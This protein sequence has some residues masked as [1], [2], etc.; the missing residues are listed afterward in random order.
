MAP[1]PAAVATLATRLAGTVVDEF[2]GVTITVA[3]ERWVEAATTA[4]D[5]EALACSY[6]DMLCGVDEGDA[7]F[8]VVA[9][10]WSPA[11]HHRLLLRTVCPRDEPIVPSLTGVFRGANWHEREAAEMYGI[12]FAGHPNL[13]PLLLPDGFGAHPM[14][15]EFLLAARA[16]KAWPGAKE[17][18]EESTRR[19]AT[20]PGQPPTDSGWPA[21]LH[22]ETIAPDPA[23]DR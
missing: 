15:K 13:V 19:A 10:L 7:G 1:E 5:D 3:P 2:G 21:P 20:A 11:H 14:R 9:H 22:S 6:F 12:T 16:V 17:P 18:G 23:A 4:R 8:G